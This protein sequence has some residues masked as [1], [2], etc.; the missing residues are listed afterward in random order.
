M[1]D[2]KKHQQYLQYQQFLLLRASAWDMY[3]S[4]VLSMSLHPGTTRDKAVPK[5][6]EQ[7]A[8][9]ADQLLAERDKRGWI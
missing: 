6:P 5:T 7:I 9:I 1:I 4:A 8:E 3:A 2:D